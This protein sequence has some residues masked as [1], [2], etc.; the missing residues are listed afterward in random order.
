MTAQV[1][2]LGILNWRWQA[3]PPATLFSTSNYR[4]IGKQEFYLVENQ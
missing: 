4:P 2:Q 1:E 3:A